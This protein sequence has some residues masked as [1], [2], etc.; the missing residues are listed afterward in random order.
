MRAEVHETVAVQFDDDLARLLLELRRDLHRH[1]ELAF[2]EERTATRLEDALARAD[3]VELKRVAGTGVVARIPG[4]NS[5]SP[6]VAVRGDIDALPIEE[7]TGLDYSSER[8]GVMHACGHDVHATWTVGAALLLSRQPAVGDVVVVLQPAEEVG[9]GAAAVLQGGALEGVGAI[10]GA[11]VD[12]RWP[13]GQVVVQ[14]GPLAAAA[15]NFR[16]ELRGDGSHGARPHE[17]RDPIPG[18][19]ALITALQTVV[20]RRVDPDRA[21]VLSIGSVEGGKAPNVIADRAALSGTLRA[22]DPQVQ[23]LLHEELRRVTEGIAQAHGLT[24]VLDIETLTPALVNAE[25]ATAW[26]RRVAH[27]LLGEGAVRPLGSR[28]MAGEDFAVYLE[29]LPGCFMRIGAREPGGEFVPGHS[30]RFAAADGSIFVGAALLA[31]TAR[32]A[33][34]ALSV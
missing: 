8:P 9:L 19:G 28:N 4:R 17:G 21:A 14:A 33:S 13:V 24:A 25:E 16:I 18:L 7:A 20:S 1:P 5:E 12:R 23:R 15:D 27:R 26:A 11:H 32:E 31:E 30:P 22:Q 34:A 10:F 6:A 29:H 2:E 3:A